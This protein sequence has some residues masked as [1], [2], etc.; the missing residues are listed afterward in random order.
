MLF[1]IHI[2]LHK[3]QRQSNLTVNFDPKNHFVI[4]SLGH[5]MDKENSHLIYNWDE[6]RTIKQPCSWFYFV[7]IFLTALLLILLCLIIQWIRKEHSGCAHKINGC[8]RLYVLSMAIWYH[9]ISLQLKSVLLKD[10]RQA[11]FPRS[12]FSLFLSY[13]P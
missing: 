10:G 5:Y 8:H 3:V 11:L 13:P 4:L 9:K 12:I 7:L 2:V 1:A 6:C